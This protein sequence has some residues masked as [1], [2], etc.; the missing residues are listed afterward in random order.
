VDMGLPSFM[1]AG[2]TG[3][4]AWSQFSQ[5]AGFEGELWVKASWDLATLPPENWPRKKDG[6][7]VHRVFVGVAT[8]A[9]LNLQECRFDG[10]DSQGNSRWEPSG[11]PLDFSFLRS[12]AEAGA[13]VYFYPCQ[14][15]GRLGNPHVSQSQLCFYEIDD[16]SVEEQWE[17]LQRLQA[18]T[19]LQP[20]AVIH[21]GG[22]SLHVYFRLSEPVDAQ[23]WKVLNRKL[24]IA[25]NGDPAGKQSSPSDA[26]PRRLPRTFGRKFGGS[27]PEGNDQGCLQP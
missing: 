5:A 23:R 3:L 11:E 8:P 7:V 9:G 2:L 19:G 12:L 21:T 4:P 27:Q 6:S 10:R 16:R 22:K 17:V 26:A 15:H 14:P 18:Q 24:T 1:D 13:T 25:A 20:C